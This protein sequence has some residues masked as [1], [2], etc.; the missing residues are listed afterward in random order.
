MFCKEK[1]V[2]A[3][4]LHKMHCDTGYQQLVII[5]SDTHNGNLKRR[6]LGIYVF[7]LERLLLWKYVFILQKKIVYVFILERKRLLHRKFL[8]IILLILTQI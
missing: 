5:D 8:C 2:F 4:L 7:T 6:S 1:I 3:T